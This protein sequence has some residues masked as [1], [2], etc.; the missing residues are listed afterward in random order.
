MAKTAHAGADGTAHGG[1]DGEG[2][3]VVAD[4]GVRLWA[5]R[6]ADGPGAPV[7]LCHGGPGIWDTLQAP[8]ALLGGRPVV[9]WDQRGCGRSERRGP[10]T[11]A[12]SIADLDAV[13]RASGWERAVLVGHSW[14]AQLALLYALERPDRVRAL[15]YVSGVGVD[16]V[17]AWHPAYE[18]GQRRRLG[19]RLARWRELNDRPASGLTESEDR[20]LCVL[21]WSADFLG[22]DALASAEAMATPWFGVNRACNTALNRELR[23]LAADGGMPERCAELTVPVLIVDGARDIRPRSA[24]DSL[25]RAL[26]QVS[27]TVLPQAGHIPWAEDPAGFAAAITAFLD[28]REE[29]RTPG[30]AP[31]A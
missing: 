31:S 21:Q 5:V 11:V 20:E 25:E 14:G 22:P 19:H 10:Y 27:R 9:R 8:A 2:I 17:S 12:R 4:D 29:P 1:G 6:A 24:V 7:I 13:R 26:P 28:G 3:D 23:D 15:V 16:D 18:E 30:A